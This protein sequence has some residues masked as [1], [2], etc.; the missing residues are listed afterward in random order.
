MQTARI[1]IPKNTN[2]NIALSR[3]VTCPA[4]C[5][6][7]GLSCY[8]WPLP[9]GL[10]KMEKLPN[11]QHFASS[12]KKFPRGHAPDPPQFTHFFHIFGN[13]CRWPPPMR[14]SGAACVPMGP[15]HLIFYIIAVM[16][17]RKI[18]SN[19]RWVDHKEQLT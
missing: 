4:N 1:G 16:Y 2:K 13:R 11:L 9:K 10:T 5:G 15:L 7:G 8:P 12:K 3:T 14:T 17:I 6:S 18:N 19:C